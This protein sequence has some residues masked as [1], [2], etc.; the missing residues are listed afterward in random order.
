MGED[1]R[2]VNIYLK[3]HNKQPLFLDDLRY[4]A[5]YDPECF[6]KTCR[7]VVYN[8]PEAEPIMEPIVKAKEEIHKKEVPAAKQPENS[9]GKWKLFGKKE[10]EKEQRQGIRPDIEAILEN[11]KQLEKDELPVSNMDAQKVKNLL[12]N[13][14]MEQIFP[15]NDRDT[16]FEIQ[17][18]NKS[19]F[20]DKKI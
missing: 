6:E 17:P 19:S 13:L 3:I 7:N 15:H 4:L 1:T 12:G 2:L 8:I 11:L 9:K 18:G 5:K 16:F 10:A 14:F 20:F